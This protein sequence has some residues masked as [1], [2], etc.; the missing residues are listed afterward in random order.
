MRIAPYLD[1]AI[2]DFELGLDSLLTDSV[3]TLE[4][5][6]SFGEA[7]VMPSSVS[8]EFLCLVSSISGI[9]KLQ[10]ITTIK[11]H[12]LWCQSRAL[13]LP[14]PLADK[15]SASKLI[16]YFSSHLVA[17]GF[18][19]SSP[20]D[21]ITLNPT[22]KETV[23]SISYFQTCIGTVAHAT[24]YTE[25]LISHTKTALVDTIASVGF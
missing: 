22:N 24:L 20:P 5:D 3:K 17:F 19:A 6:S 1:Q 11:S 13:L 14:A 25:Q 21:N 16:C 9:S 2:K 23:Q 4:V 18:Q 12:K 15:M 10:L 8:S 7:D